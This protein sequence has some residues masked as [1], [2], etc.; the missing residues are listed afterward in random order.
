M[1]NAVKVKL[2]KLYFLTFFQS[3]LKKILKEL[4]YT[5][6]CPFIFRLELLHIAI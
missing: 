6:V 1:E 4:F 3:Y 2:E 5:D